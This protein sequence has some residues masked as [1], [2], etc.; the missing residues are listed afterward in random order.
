MEARQAQARADGEK[1]ATIKRA[2]G[3]QQRLIL[4]ANGQAAANKTV[5]ATITDELIRYE[6]VKRIGDDIKVLILPSGQQFILGEDI[7]GPG[8]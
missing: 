8:K 6:L 4:E 7:L 3:E 1:N 5:T 2:E